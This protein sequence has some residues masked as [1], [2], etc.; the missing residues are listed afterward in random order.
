MQIAT[1]LLHLVDMVGA[2][3]GGGSGERDAAKE[4][5]C[6]EQPV[7]N[8]GH[9]IAERPVAS[10]SSACCLC[11]HRIQRCLVRTVERREQSGL[12]PCGTGLCR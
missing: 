10:Y 4:L 5:K 6:N 8:N 9:N 1:C 11:S 2:G 12:C 7:P 3:G